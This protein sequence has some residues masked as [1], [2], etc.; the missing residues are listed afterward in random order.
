M[1]VEGVFFQTPSTPANL[2]ATL[3]TC[4]PSGLWNRSRASSAVLALPRPSP[5]R[6]D[7][8]VIISQMVYVN[9]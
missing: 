5:P 2:P 8:T 7:L 1:R 6:L 4:Q 3:H 9:S